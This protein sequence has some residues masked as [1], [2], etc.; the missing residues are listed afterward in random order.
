MFWSTEINGTSSDSQCATATLLMLSQDSAVNTN[1]HGYN[2]TSS[3]AVDWFRDGTGR[4]PMPG[5]KGTTL[6]SLFVLVSFFLLY[7]RIISV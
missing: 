1:I 5:L 2:I 4:K 6:G 7:F 3:S